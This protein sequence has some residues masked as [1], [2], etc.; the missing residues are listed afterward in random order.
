MGDPWEETPRVQVPAER[1]LLKPVHRQAEGRTGA[2]MG[3]GGG[4]GDLEP[5]FTRSGARSPPAPAFI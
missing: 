2:K 5:E 3:G 1:V 4:E